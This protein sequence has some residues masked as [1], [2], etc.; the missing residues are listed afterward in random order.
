MKILNI[1]SITELR[2][3]DVQMYTVYNL[4]KD[5]SDLKQYIL[6]PEDSVLA[7]ICKKDN[8]RFF[9]YKKNKLKLINFVIAIVKICRKESISI[10]HIHDST[11]LMTEP[12]CGDIIKN[13]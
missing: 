1:T 9:I 2:G 5:K 4:L 13:V 3:G 11:A 6:C 8:A 7:G 10:I 12:D